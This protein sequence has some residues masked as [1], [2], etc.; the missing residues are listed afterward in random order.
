MDENARFGGSVYGVLAVFKLSWEWSLRVS[1]VCCRAAVVWCKEFSVVGGV[2]FCAVC[3]VGCVFSW[4]DGVG[5]RVSRD[6]P[7]NSRPEG[8]AGVFEFFVF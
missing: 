7:R 1:G 2:G 3:G 8:A 5:A 4:G 6:V